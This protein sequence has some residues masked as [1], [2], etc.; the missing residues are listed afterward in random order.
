M[1]LLTMT[2]AIVRAVNQ[3]QDPIEVLR[4]TTEPGLKEPAVGKPISHG[5]VLG[6]AKALRANRGRF[7]QDDAAP[8]LPYHLEDLLRGSKVYVEAPVPKPEPVIVP[9][10]A[11]KPLLSNLDHRVQSSHEPPAS[12]RR[13]SSL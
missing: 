3:L 7:Q 10:Q 12:R 13:G 2:P 11:P 8:D 1:V 4:E 9:H 6:I 5:Q